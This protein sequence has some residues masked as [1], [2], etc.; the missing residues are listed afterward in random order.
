MSFVIRYIVSSTGADEGQ[1]FAAFSIVRSGGITNCSRTAIQNFSPG[2]V[3]VGGRSAGRGHAIAGVMNGAAPP[4]ARSRAN[5]RRFMQPP[6]QPGYS[7]TL[8]MADAILR[9]DD[10]FLRMSAARL[11]MI[12]FS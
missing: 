6:L 8:P 1:R 4:T 10:T 2:A 3:G 7:R 11:G 5:S 12:L 9:H